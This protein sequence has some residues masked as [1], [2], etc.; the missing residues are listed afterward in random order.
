MAQIDYTRSRLWRFFSQTSSRSSHRN[1]DG[2]VSPLPRSFH[3]HFPLS[4][5]FLAPSP[6]LLHPTRSNTRNSL[7]IIDRSKIGEGGNDLS[8][9]NGDTLFSIARAHPT[10]TILVPLRSSPNLVAPSE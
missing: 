6:S 8:L 5:R 2:T 4:S 1:R 7:G 3:L 10:N 9:F